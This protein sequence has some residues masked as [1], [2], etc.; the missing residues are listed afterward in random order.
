MEVVLGPERRA[1]PVENEGAAGGTIV[2]GV[3]GSPQA[4][5][6]V[7]WALEESRVHG[8]DLVLVHVWQFPPVGLTHY[9]DEVRSIS[10]F[11]ELRSLA[12]DMMARLAAEADRRAPGVRVS[13]LVVEGHPAAALVEAATGARLLVVGSRGLGG[14]KGMLMGSVSTACAQHARCPVVI[15]PDEES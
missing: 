10:G 5:R 6:A 3:D 9:A 15:V 7:D 12:D 14:F 8:D 1:D 13:S 11:E 2:V 4:E